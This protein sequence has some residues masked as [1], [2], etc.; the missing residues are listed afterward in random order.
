MQTSSNEPEG[1][2]ETTPSSA[3][4]VTYLSYTAVRTADTKP[5]SNCNAHP[6]I[7]RPTSA[8]ECIWEPHCWADDRNSPRY[9]QRPLADLNLRRREWT[10]SPPISH[11]A[12]HCLKTADRP[13]YIIAGEEDRRYSSTTKQSIHQLWRSTRKKGEA[14]SR[15]QRQT[16][17]AERRRG[18]GGRFIWWPLGRTGRDKM[19]RLGFFVQST[20][21]T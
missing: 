7:H 9:T 4:V 14:L 21:V 17:N 15:L 2:R 6:S 3:T 1:E 10:E 12:H 13:C 11:Q 8:T 19:Q 16:P 18:A 20:Q 5:P